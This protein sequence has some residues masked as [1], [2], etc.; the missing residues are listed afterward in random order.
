MNLE[1]FISRVRTLPSV[2]ENTDVIAIVDWFIEL[3]NELGK[4]I[5]AGQ[6]MFDTSNI[7]NFVPLADITKQTLVDW[8]V[9]AEG[10]REFLDLLMLEHQAII[11]RNAAIAATGEVALPFLDSP[12]GVSTAPQPLSVGAQSL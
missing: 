4:S 2:G 12:V 9:T 1:F 7:T 3:S 8:F 10:G 6:T 5:A 11:N